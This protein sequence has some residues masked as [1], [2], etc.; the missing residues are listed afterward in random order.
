M[1]E[2]RARI[3][4]VDDEPPM[5][6]M[7]TDFLTEQGFEVVPAYSGV[8]A[9]TRLA[10]QPADVVLLDVRMPE[11]DGVDVL[12][13]I[14]ENYP[15]IGILMV[16]GNDDVELAKETISLGA[17]DYV[18][19]PV[20]FPYLMRAIDK[21]LAAAA[22]AAA[23]EAATEGQ[24]AEAP[25]AAPSGSLH[26]LLYDLALEIFRATRALSP[27]ARESVGVSLEQAALDAVQRGV[28][29]EK[30]EIIRALN[31]VRTMLRFARDL[32]DFS[33]DQHRRLE[34]YVARAR[35]AAGLS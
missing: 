10:Q 11:L 6:Q 14:R 25:A 20:D 3:L 28:G 33:D 30:G 4:V 13:R 34:S 32:G 16:S 31:Q 15:R 18:L 5:V 35:R 21:I 19:K 2:R 9:L 17:F 1:A 12:K 23:A 8:Q 22:A 26:G 24:T 29:G 7:I 27:T